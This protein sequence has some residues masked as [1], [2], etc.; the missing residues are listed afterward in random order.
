MP[1]PVT[2]VD[3]QREIVDT[4]RY[5]SSSFFSMNCD[6]CKRDLSPEEPIYRIRAHWEP[7]KEPS[8]AQKAGFRVPRPDLSSW[9]FP[10][11]CRGCLDARF[12]DIIGCDPMDRRPTQ[13]IRERS[14]WMAPRF[15]ADPQYGDFRSMAQLIKEC[16]W[17]QWR[18]GACRRPLY[19][20]QA[21][22]VSVPQRTTCNDHCQTTLTA[23][24]RLKARH[25]A[26][27]KTLVCESCKKKFPT[28]R[29]S[30]GT[31]YCSATCRQRAHRLKTKEAQS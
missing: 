8:P 20:Y 25:A 9:R 15:A 11:L 2:G 23:M 6:I 26:R 16:F 17:R 24:R 13:L 28:P 5:E 18:C 29:R 12:A 30:R 27:P 10:W 21:F 22:G 1:V 4:I 3:R 31:R 7:S 19:Y 14:W